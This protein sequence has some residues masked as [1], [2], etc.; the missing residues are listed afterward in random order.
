MRG[1][2]PLSG[3]EASRRIL[4]PEWG[5]ASRHFLLLPFDS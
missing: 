2:L 1:E 4:E 3:G 5:N